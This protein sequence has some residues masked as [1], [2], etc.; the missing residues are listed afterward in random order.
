MAKFSLR[1]VN[2]TLHS[3]H[4]KGYNIDVVREFCYEYRGHLVSPN[5]Y[6]YWATCNRAAKLSGVQIIHIFINLN[7]EEKPD[8]YG[9]APR[10]FFVPED[11]E[12]PK[13]K[14]A[15]NQGNGS[16]SMAAKEKWKRRKEKQLDIAR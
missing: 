10:M 3:R 13:Q 9:L 5:I 12:P 1:A 16:W 14:K 15:K 2:G 6:S 11:F 4:I 7:L 8:P